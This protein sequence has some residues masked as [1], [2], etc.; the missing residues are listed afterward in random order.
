MIGLLS[1]FRMNPGQTPSQHPHG[2]GFLV[3]AVRRR[4]SF[5]WATA[6]LLST[7][8]LC[9]CKQ[10][11]VAAGTDVGARPG[12]SKTGAPPVSVTTVR[13]QRRDYPVQIEATGTVTSLNT[14]DVKPQITSTVT[15]VHI[16]EGQFVKT[17]QLLFTLDARPAQTDVAKAHAQLQR[18]L[19]SLADA[20]RQLARSKELVAQNFVSQTAVDTN[21]TLVDA[22]SA[23][24]ESDRAALQAAQVGLSYTQIK[25]PL[26]GRA[27]IIGVYPGTLVQPTAATALV[28]ITQLDPIAVTFNLPQRDL[29]SAL[30]LLRKG[31]GSVAAVLPE[32]RGTMQG[33]LAFVDNS[34]DAATG[35]VKVKAQFANPQDQLW[36]GAFVGV[37]LAVRTLK[38]V[39]VVPQ[40][41]IVQ[42]AHGKVLYVVGPANTAELREI[43]VEHAAGLDAVVTGVQPGERVVLE[44]RQNVRPGSKLV[45]RDTART[46]GPRAAAAE[47]TGVASQVATARGAKGAP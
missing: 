18:D 45:E 16:K 33:K 15:Q 47:S 14:V 27:G 5:A 8:L 4:S 2:R 34:V 20:R 3:F 21:Q 22:Q 6:A 38:D 28:T 42:G 41:S 7:A 12:A 36:P 26:S 31:G 39:V 29:P 37:Q 1:P 25:A 46:A 13:A 43:A 44:G 35:T 11:Q 32:G 9:A 19:A 30:E 17:G 23:A 10:E 24:V 40:A